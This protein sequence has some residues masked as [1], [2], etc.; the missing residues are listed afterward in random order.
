[1]FHNLKYMC[2]NFLQC[3]MKLAY[4]D[5]MHLVE[6]LKLNSMLGVGK[7]RSYLVGNMDNS[8]VVECMINKH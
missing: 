1:M 7:D 3:S 8:F 6:S 2:C 4:M 5:N